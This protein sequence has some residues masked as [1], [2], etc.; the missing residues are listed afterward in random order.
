[1]SEP[2]SPI[3]SVTHPP[4]HTRLTCC[5]SDRVAE[6][7]AIRD[8]RVPGRVVLHLVIVVELATHAFELVEPAFAF[9][10]DTELRTGDVVGH[11]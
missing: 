5:R 1:M 11:A 3:H 10:A 9:Y 8:R 4:I 6:R 7:N 2:G